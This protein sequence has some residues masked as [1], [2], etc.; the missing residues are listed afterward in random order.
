V[1]LPVNTGSVLT[2]VAEYRGSY[3]TVLSA[4][5]ADRFATDIFCVNLRNQFEG[6]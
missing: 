3:T 6:N 1:L 5:I 4:K 2:F